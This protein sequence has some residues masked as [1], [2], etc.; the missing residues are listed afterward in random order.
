MMQYCNYIIIK[1]NT[2]KINVPLKIYGRATALLPFLYGTALMNNNTVIF[3]TF[4]LYVSWYVQKFLLMDQIWYLKFLT[5][6]LTDGL[7]L[8]DRY[9][10][11]YQIH[12]NMVDVYSLFLIF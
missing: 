1:K 9:N 11:E 3:I 8:Q 6:L 10:R 5:V 2:N 12:K 7:L 4:L